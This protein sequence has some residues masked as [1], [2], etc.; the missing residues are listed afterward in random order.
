[1]Q[2]EKLP[3]VNSIETIWVSIDGFANKAQLCRL[4]GDRKWAVH[5]TDPWTRSFTVVCY[6]GDTTEFSKSTAM[7]MAEQYIRHGRE[8]L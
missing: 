6:D 4:V 8:F 1:M 7:K 5:G 3:I 2:I